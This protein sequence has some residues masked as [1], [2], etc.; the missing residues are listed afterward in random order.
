[1]SKFLALM[2]VGTAAVA[3]IACQAIHAQP[4]H[5]LLGM[6]AALGVAVVALTA[7]SGLTRKRV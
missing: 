2:G 3:G 1:M 7:G 6:V 4:A 5:N